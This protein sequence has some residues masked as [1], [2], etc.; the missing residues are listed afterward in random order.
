M[1]TLRGCF[2]KYALLLASALAVVLVACTAARADS[3]VYNV[4]GTFSNGQILTGQITWNS[5]LSSATSSVLTLSG[6]TLNAVCSSPQGGC[7][8]VLAGFWG[9]GNWSKS[10]EILLGGFL[11]K[12]SLFVLTLMN[13]SGIKILDTKLTWRVVAMPE[14]PLVA[15]LLA[16]CAAFALMSL[17]V[18]VTR[19][20]RSAA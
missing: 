14:E 2:S 1:K 5:T 7:G 12:D 11:P 8:A 13:G 16:V 15:D 6:S 4:S 20:R 10:Y 19:F 9:T 18:P 3:V 17:L